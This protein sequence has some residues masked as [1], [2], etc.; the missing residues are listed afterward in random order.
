M[1]LLYLYTL[2]SA[3]FVKLGFKLLSTSNM[4]STHQI[5]LP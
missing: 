5:E 4:F 1:F 2:K 3:N